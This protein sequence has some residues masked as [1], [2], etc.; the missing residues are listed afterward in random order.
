MVTKLK[1][2]EKFVVWE[3]LFTL[4]STKTTYELVKFLK[5]GP[6]LK[7]LIIFIRNSRAFLFKTQEII[8]NSTFRKNK[9]PEL[10]EKVR[11]DKPVLLSN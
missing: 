8:E 3:Q 2:L 5:N 4:K 9:F 1:F 6:K 11:N 10:P 7:K